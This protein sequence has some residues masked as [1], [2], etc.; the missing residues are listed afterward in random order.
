MK[1]S[2]FDETKI[3]FMAE[4]MSLEAKGVPVLDE[5]SPELITSRENALEKSKEKRRQKSFSYMA[6]NNPEK[7]ANQP[8][9]N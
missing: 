5:G 4:Q 6:A 8:K 7:K 9:K 3:K 2:S 1:K